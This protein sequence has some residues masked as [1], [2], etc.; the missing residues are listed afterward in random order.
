M[1][2]N[3]D[4]IRGHEFSAV[5]NLGTPLWVLERHGEKADRPTFDVPMAHGSWLPILTPATELGFSRDFPPST[6]A[7]DVGQIPTDGG[8]FLPFLIARREIIEDDDRTPDEKIA[9]LNGLYG[10]DGRFRKFRRH[11]GAKL[12]DQWC[13]SE[14]RSLPSVGEKT[15]K[16]LMKAGF[17]SP[18][19]VAAAED[20]VLLSI[21]GVGRKLVS[22]IRTLA[23]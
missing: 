2:D 1:H 6:M 20:D 10:A 15:A 8:D 22:R 23:E 3:S 9:A 7:S 18:E 12:G 21:P 5:L 14:L 4:I 13:I 16:A 11:L 17:R 19:D